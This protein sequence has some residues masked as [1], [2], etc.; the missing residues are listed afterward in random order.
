MISGLLLRGAVGE[1]RVLRG[2]L[3]HQ[4]TLLEIRIRFVPRGKGGGARRGGGRERERIVYAMLE[5]T[6]STIVL[7]SVQN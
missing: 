6:F 7:Q 4:Q 1:G 3:L 2:T 5:L